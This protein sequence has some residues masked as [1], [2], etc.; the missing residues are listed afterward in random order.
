VIAPLRRAHARATLLLTLFVPAGI[1]AGVAARQPVP[2]HAPAN[3]RLAR[4]TRAGGELEHATQLDGEQRITLRWEIVR[5]AERAQLLLAPEFDLELPDVLVY[6]S[7]SAITT[8]AGTDAL[9]LG[10]LAGSETRRLPLPSPDTTGGHV[11][12]YSLAHQAIVAGGTLS[13]E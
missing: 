2:A 12:L 5:D 10:T 6:W 13:E 4:P 7:A 8:L 9:L 3:V 1:A 11:T